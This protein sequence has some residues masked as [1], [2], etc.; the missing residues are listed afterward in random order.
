MV[1]VEVE[2]GPPV[3]VEVGP[4]V[5]VL[6]VDVEVVG[7]PVVVGVLHAVLRSSAGAVGRVDGALHPQ[8]SQSSSAMFQA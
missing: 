5:V 1:D 8:W 3:E 4:P 2:V 7:S 6:E